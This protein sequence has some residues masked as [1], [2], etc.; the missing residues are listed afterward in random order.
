M[1]DVEFIKQLKTL[2]LLA[3]KKIISSYAGGQQ[4]LKQETQ[5][6]YELAI[7]L[8]YGREF[9]AAQAKL[10]HILQRNPRD[11]G[12]WRFMINSTQMVEN[13]TSV[14]WNGVTVMKEK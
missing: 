12:A 6:Q 4:S 13:G 7:N 9:E 3:K 10:L 5:T 2:D 8:Y 14:D 11:K 1:I